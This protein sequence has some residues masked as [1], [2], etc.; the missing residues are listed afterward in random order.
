MLRLLEN[1]A[2]SCQAGDTA[3]CELT[4]K[5]HYNALHLLSGTWPAYTVTFS[6][7][8]MFIMPR[9]GRAGLSMA[10]WC[11]SKVTSCGT[12][13]ADPFAGVHYG[14]PHRA[15][16]GQVWSWLEESGVEINTACMNAYVSTLAKQARSWRT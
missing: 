2:A 12:P 10:C 13:Q 8:H 15:C 3:D 6:S 9:Q 1:E 11:T 7:P 4:I 5:L 14:P 16:C